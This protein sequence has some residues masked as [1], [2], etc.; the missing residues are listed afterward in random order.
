MSSFGFNSEYLTSPGDEQKIFY[1]D[2][3][4]MMTDSSFCLVSSSSITNSSETVQMS[5]GSYFCYYNR[6][7]ASS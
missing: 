6:F 1:R 2:D 7:S 3:V 5:M 4:F